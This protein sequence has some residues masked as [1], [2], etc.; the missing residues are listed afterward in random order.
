MIYDEMPLDLRKDPKRLAFVYL[1]SGNEKLEEVLKPCVLPNLQGV[2]D[3]LE[4]NKMSKEEQV[5]C[6]LAKELLEENTSFDF[7]ELF[8]QLNESN[9]ELALNA[10][11]LRYN[12]KENGYYNATDTNSYL[13]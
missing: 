2:N 12:K 1:I 5:L 8:I 13:K 6:N 3:D 11:K 10:L 9:L 7:K 4:L